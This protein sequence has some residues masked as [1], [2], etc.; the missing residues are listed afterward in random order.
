[1]NND[2]RLSRHDVVFY[3]RGVA[4]HAWHY[5]AGAPTHA[6][7]PC[8]VMANGLA[9]TRASGLEPFAERLMGAGFDVLLF[10]YR[11]F[12]DSQGEPRQ[13]LTVGHQL[14]D[15]RAAVACARA[16]PGV[17]AQRIALW[18]VSLSGGHVVSLAAED[19][20]VAAICALVP[21]VDG[22]A[23]VHLVLKGAGL[24]R[25]LRLCLYGAV[26]QLRGLAGLKPLLIPV[27]ARPGEFSV[28]STADAYDGYSAVAAK[29]WVNRMSARIAFTLGLYRPIAKAS[30]L[31][32]PALIQ[33][34]MD[35]V[36]VSPAAAI[37]LGRR[38]G[39]R[40]ELKQYAGMGHF[41]GLVGQGFET[42]IADQLGFF[43]RVLA[44]RQ[45]QQSIGR[46]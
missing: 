6:Q 24:G 9:G 35:D 27:V 29:G 7:R 22:L 37:E 46:S 33:A 25:L 5:R 8:I 12:G 40:A 43:Q 11:F 16:L 17:D 45:T 34:C 31:I 20:R 26:D 14:D 2:L 28:L 30:Q 15:W 21:M 42:T 44:P 41:D 10:D 1:M 38:I 23:A 32:C 36:V 39:E 19:L 3:S 18:G 4:C 13:L